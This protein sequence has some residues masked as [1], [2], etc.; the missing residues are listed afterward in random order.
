M[1]QMWEWA[2]RNAEQA[3]SFAR[4]ESTGGSSRILGWISFDF[5]SSGTI[6]LGNWMDRRFD[7]K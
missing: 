6:I 3:G 4:I 1:C 2:A 5:G 7:S